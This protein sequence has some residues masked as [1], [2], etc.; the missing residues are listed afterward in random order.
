MGFYRANNYRVNVKASRD[1]K[2]LPENTR[3][4]WTINDIRNMV[5]HAR[6]LRDR[7]IILVQFQSGMDDSTFCSLNIG[8]VRRELQENRIP[9]KLDLQRRKEGLPYISFIGKDGVEALKVYLQE[10]IIK[11][12][13]KGLDDFKDEEPLF[14]VESWKRKKLER[15]QPRHIQSV[16]RGLALETGLITKEYLESNHWNPVR[17]HALR[18]AFMSLMRSAGLNEQDIDFMVGHKIPYQQAY[19]QREGERL[20]KIYADAMYVLSVFETRETISE[21]ETKLSKQIQEQNTIISNL[22]ARN[23][24]LENRLKMF[25]S[26]IDEFNK[27]KEEVEF[28]KSDGVLIGTLRKLSSEEIKEV[29]EMAEG[30]RSTKA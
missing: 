9:L 8:H 14:I 4:N 7:A 20:R 28:L 11:E 21:I 25:E 17:A 2:A 26:F 18:S 16:F 5:N 30:G 19:Y 15:I 23:E 24:E 12:G 6:S 27:I 22:V 13:R 10:Q 1:F 3:F 29:L